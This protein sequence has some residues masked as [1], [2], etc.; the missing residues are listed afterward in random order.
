MT[1]D[2]QGPSAKSTNGPNAQNGCQKV[3]NSNHIGALSSSKAWGLF[4]WIAEDVLQ[5][6]VRIW[7]DDVDSSEFMENN[8]A[9]VD[10]AGSFV[11]FIGDKCFFESRLFL[12]TALALFGYLKLQLNQDLLCQVVTSTSLIHV[13]NC[14]E[15]LISFTSRQIKFGTVVWDQTNQPKQHE[16]EQNNW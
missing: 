3:W 2:E 6:C 5:D 8:L 15:S 14:V 1:K 12:W 11:L 9:K 16:S 7:Q 13:M 4:W 10:P